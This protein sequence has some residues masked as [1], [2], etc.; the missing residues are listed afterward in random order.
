MMMTRGVMVKTSSVLRPASTHIR[1]QPRSKV[2]G[3]LYLKYT[4][5]LCAVM[6]ENGT[7]RP[8]SSTKNCAIPENKVAAFGKSMDF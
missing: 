8:R 5:F 6:Q 2:A 3:R 4:S 1:V 7:R